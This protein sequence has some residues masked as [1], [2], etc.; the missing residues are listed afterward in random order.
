MRRFS[1]MTLIFGAVVIAMSSLVS[2]ASA[3]PPGKEMSVVDIPDKTK[4]LKVVLQG[5]YVF[6]HDDDKMAQGE[7]CFYVYEYSED[8]TGK[9]EARPD[10][11]VVS[12][13]CQPT[14][15]G[16]ANQIVL[17]FGVVSVGLFELREIQFSGSSEGHRVP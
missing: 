4:L 7:P 12:F 17:T 3:A 10:K 15:R 6:I 14:P 5:K 1:I 2:F 16:K 11:L 13:H 8:Q 9:P